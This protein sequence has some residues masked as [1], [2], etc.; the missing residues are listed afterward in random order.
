[1]MFTGKTIMNLAADGKIN[2]RLENKGVNKLNLF[3]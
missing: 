1:M 3:G 2:L